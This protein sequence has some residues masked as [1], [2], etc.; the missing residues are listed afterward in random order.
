MTLKNRKI[1]DLFQPFSLCLS[2]WRSFSSPEA[3]SGAAGDITTVD[4]ADGTIII[5]M[6]ARLLAAVLAGA[7][8]MAAEVFQ[9]AGERLTAAD[10]AEAFSLKRA[11]SCVILV[12]IIPKWI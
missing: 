10:P 9:V 6:A 7:D 8:S 1:P 3:D 2:C 5:T 4:S 11:V 12:F